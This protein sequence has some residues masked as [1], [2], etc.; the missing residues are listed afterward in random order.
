MKTSTKHL[1]SI[2]LLFTLLPVITSVMISKDYYVKD[3]GA[4]GNGTTNDLDALQNA[5]TAFINDNTP[6]TLNFEANKVYRCSSNTEE[7]LFNIS[8]KKDKTVIGNGAEI[9]GDV[10]ILGARINNCDN[11]EIN[12]LTFDYKTLSFTQ[13]KITAVDPEGSFTMEIEAGFPM[14]SEYSTPPSTNGWGMIWGPTGYEIKNELIWIDQRIH[15]GGR[16]VKFVVRENNIKDLV[17]IDINDRYTCDIVAKKTPF[18][19]ILSSKNITYKNCSYYSARAQVFVSRYNTGKL[20]LD[21]VEIRRRP[22]TTRLLSAYRG[23]LIWMNNRMGPIIENCHIEGICD[24]GIN[25]Y[26]YYAYV[27]ETTSNNTFKL[28]NTENMEVGDTLVFINMKEG[29]EI[30]RTTIASLN[31]N[32]V[33]TTSNIS[34]VVAGETD[35]QTTTYVMNLNISCPGFVIRNNTFKDHRRFCILCRTRDG[36]IENNTG[37]NTGGGLVIINEVKAFDEGPFPG[38]ISIKN[39]S[40][41]NIR[42]WPLRIHAATWATRPDQLISDI[43]LVNNTFSSCTEGEHVASI[44]NSRNIELINNTFIDSENDGIELVNCKNIVFN[45][46]NTLNNTTITSIDDGISKRKMLDTEIIFD[47]SLSKVEDSSTTADQLFTLIQQG[48]LLN[49]VTSIP[50][51]E[52]T[53]YDINGRKMHTSVNNNQIRLNASTFVSGVYVVHIYGNGQGQVSKIVL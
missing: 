10:N 46:E 44:E 43:R 16:S 22:G 41:T 15:M 26:S 6:S 33:T 7:T 29:K 11:I 9:L 31:N 5:I 23:G 37:D 47:C 45:C 19:L 50:N 51:Y 1:R 30:G 49:I 39:N 35:A 28:H 24:D 40:F 13:G 32:I 48:N 4:V 53:I 52:V 21:G 18:N 25:M 36:V 34:N 14:P 12:G 20:H 2:V 42:R 27:N 3:Y 8:G 17:D 38:K